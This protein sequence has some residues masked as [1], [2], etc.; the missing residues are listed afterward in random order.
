MVPRRYHK[1]MGLVRVV[2][3]NVRELQQR[4]KIAKDAQMKVD[5]QKW[6]G[7]YP[8]LSAGFASEDRRR[9]KLLTACSLDTSYGENI[10]AVMLGRDG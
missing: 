3:G 9:G 5:F 1:V 2:S 8:N 10:G 4:K 6:R 7:E